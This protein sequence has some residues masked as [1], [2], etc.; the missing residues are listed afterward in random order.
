MPIDVIMPKM[1]MG[2]SEGK[3]S[4]W[5]VQDGDSVEAGQ[6]VLE[7]ETDK[8]TA[9]MT[10]DV[11]GVISVVVAEGEVVDVGTVL[12]RIEPAEGAVVRPQAQGSAEGPS[13]EILQV[14]GIALNVQQSGEGPAVVFI[15]GLSSSMELWT[16]LDQAGLEGRTLISYDLRGHGRSE[17]TPGAHTLRK[18]TAD[19][20]AL[21]ET[22]GIEQA[23]LVGHSLGA[24]IAVELAAARPE[25]VRSL[26]L[27][28]TT[29]AFPQET[30]NTLFELASA[31]TFGGMEGI[32]D[33][34]IEVTFR[35]AFRDAN[36]KVVEA[37]RRSILSSDAASIVAATRMVAKADLRPRLG[38]LKCPTQ[39][40]VG[41]EDSLT[42]PDLSHQLADAIEG[43]QL[44]EL[45]DCGHAA[46]VEQPAL[47]TRLLAKFV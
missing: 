38:S 32:A 18:H 9:E 21:L 2:M 40:L 7:V 46:P 29:A 35:P 24:M 6:V 8:A 22:V 30:R 31:A 39:V 1:G 4:R 26:S 37:I 47:V 17:Q 42:P 15:H 36:P 3:L 5:Q 45:P 28:S 27:L 41:S 23:S 25:S 19:L 33:P 14:N 16:G 34:L 11:D 13:A 10:A 12:G 44:H 43:A 20:A